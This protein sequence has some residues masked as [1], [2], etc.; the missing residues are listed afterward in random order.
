MRSTWLWALRRDTDAERRVYGTRLRRL[1]AGIEPV[2]VTHILWAE[3]RRQVAV[4]PVHFPRDERVG[5]LPVGRLRSSVVHV[6]HER[7]PGGR[8]DPTAAGVV[9]E[10]ALLNVVAHPD[11]GHELRGVPDEPRIGVVVA[12]PGLAGGGERESRL[13]HRG[14]RGA[15]TDDILHHV[16]HPTGMLGVHHILAARLGLPACL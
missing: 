8:H 16:H 1:G 3:R 2:P 14:E 9:L 11:P 4:R 5:P 6:T 7:R 10:D 13:P 12:G 15:A